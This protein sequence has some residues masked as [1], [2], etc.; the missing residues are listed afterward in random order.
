MSHPSLGRTPDP[1]RTTPLTF[2]AGLPSVTGGGGHTDRVLGGKYGVRGGR[3][4]NKIFHTGGPRSYRVWGRLPF[5]L[6]RLGNT[7]LGASGPLQDPPSEGRDGRNHRALSGAPRIVPLPYHKEQK[8]SGTTRPTP[9]P[10]PRPGQVSVSQ[11]E[12]QKKQETKTGNT[13]RF[14]TGGFYGPRLGTSDSPTEIYLNLRRR[15]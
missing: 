2:R 8:K 15:P 6:R 4:R 13:I 10:E 1:R 5:T 9:V 7:S 11:S 3:R 12:S 14:T